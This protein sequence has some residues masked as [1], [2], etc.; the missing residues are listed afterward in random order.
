MIEQEN[1]GGLCL[2]AY[3]I[4]IF[5]ANEIAKRFHRNRYATKQSALIGIRLYTKKKHQLVIDS[6]TVRFLL[7][8]AYLINTREQVD[9]TGL[10]N[11]S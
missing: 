11:A 2:S 5:L 3:T 7:C 1:L 8:D 9:L 4:K 10:F 6:T